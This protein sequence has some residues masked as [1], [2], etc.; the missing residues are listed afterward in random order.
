MCVSTSQILLGQF[1]FYVNNSLLA[2]SFNSTVFPYPDGSKLEL[3]P[4]A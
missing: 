3:L 2:F 4:I 1:F